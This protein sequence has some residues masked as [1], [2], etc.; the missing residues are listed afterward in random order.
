[1]AYSQDM[2]ARDIHED[3]TRIFR[4]VFD[5][6][7]LSLHPTTTAND[8]ADW[9]SLTHVHL[10]VAMEECF[11]IRFLSG[12]LQDLQDVG[13]FE[14]LIARKLAHRPTDAPHAQTNPQP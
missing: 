5:D 4:S 14:S 1:M 13:E 7:S 8:I 12:E 10:V 3:V 9:T 2:D 11:G 6:A